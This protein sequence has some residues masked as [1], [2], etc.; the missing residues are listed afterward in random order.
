MTSKWKATYAVLIILAALSLWA[1]IVLA[2]KDSV[3]MKIRTNGHLIRLVVD[4][5]Q[6]GS[7]DMGE[8]REVRVTIQ[9]VDK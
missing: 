8:Q 2:Q 5:E 3:V 6:V 9:R 4:D 7:I 1:S